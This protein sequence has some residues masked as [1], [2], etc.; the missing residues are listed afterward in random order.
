MEHSTT[1]EVN[2]TND[3]RIKAILNSEH[4]HRIVQVQLDWILHRVRSRP[5]E[6]D[7]PADGA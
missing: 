5:Q 3:G 1:L 2:A 4:L 7:L 6:S